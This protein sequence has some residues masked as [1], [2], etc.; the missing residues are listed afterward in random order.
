VKGNLRPH[1]SSRNI[2]DSTLFVMQPLALSRSPPGN[3]LVRRGQETRLDHNSGR[4]HSILVHF[5]SNQIETIILLL[6]F[7]CERW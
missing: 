7:S 1:L 5:C 3:R 4:V 2:C 6:T